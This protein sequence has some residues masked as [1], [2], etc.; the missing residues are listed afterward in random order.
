MIILGINAYHADASAALLRDGELLAAVEEERFN[1]IKHA[2]GFP[3]QAIQACLA[4]ANVDAG[5]IDHFAV[6]RNP[7]ANMGRKMLFAL[8]RRPGRSLVADRLRNAGRVGNLAETIR[9]SLGLTGGIEKRLHYIEHHPA[10]L[11]SSFFVSPFD[12]AAVCAIDGFGDFVSTSS[13]AGFG[14]SIKMLDRIF[15]PHSIGLVYLALTQYLG[16]TKF[17][18]EF[19]VMGLAPYGTPRY[20]A[21]LRK[22]VRLKD[23][24]CFELDL[25]YFRHWNGGVTMS[26]D[27]GEP[28]LGKVFSPKLEEL[29]GPARNPAEPVAGR[30]EDIAASLQALY[31]EVA[32]HIL[33]ALHAR[34]KLDRLCLAGGCAM[35]SVANGK[36]RDSTP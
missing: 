14:N 19:K 8:T 20:L 3:H 36:I 24:G 17:G 7:K 9:D 22:L 25:T 15:F 26:W 32:F 13:A 30:D 35:N 31:E 4:M 18:D 16:F 27:D 12:T 23:Q 2:A 33:R 34:T 29:L 11:A 21:E 28:V 6:S 10:H 1:R 5:E